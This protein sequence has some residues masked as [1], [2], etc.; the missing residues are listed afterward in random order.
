MSLG[1]RRRRPP[2]PGYVA[3]ALWRRAGAVPSFHINPAALG[4]AR[5]LI[6]GTVL[7]GGT[8]NSATP[9]WEAGPGGILAQPAANSPV[10]AYDPVTLRPLGLRDWQGVTNLILDSA[11][12]SAASYTKTATTV[13]A[14]GTGPDNQ[15]AYSINETTSTTSHTI[16]PSA[17]SVT[18]GV[19]YTAS[20]FLKRSTVDWVQLTVG[21]AGFSNSRFANFNL[22]TG[23]IGIQSNCTGFIEPYPN[24]WYRCSIRVLAVATA[25]SNS[26]I[27]AFT[28]N[29]DSATRLPSYAGSTSNEVLAA[30]VAFT[31]TSGPAPYVP[32]TATTASSTAEAIDITSLPGGINNIRTVY[33]R[34]R[35]PASGIRGIISLNDNSSSNRLE[36]L[37]NGTD[38]R[39]VAVTSGSTVA[40][41]NGGTIAANT[42][43]K[44]AA[45]FDGDN[46]AVSINGA[47]VVTDN[48]G[49]RAIVDRIFLGR[50]Q[51]GEHLNGIIEELA[52]WTQPLGNSQLQAVAA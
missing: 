51:A 49:A 48:A 6:T 5:D 26:L 19:T 43:F 22:A 12:L 10:I 27:L 4:H 23:T 47:P 11:N 28:N 7:G 13:S 20:I 33:A 29:T 24:G 36:L 42:T 50:T 1:A 39:A 3:N 8:V 34:V 16:G 41:I 44:I 37:T 30:L 9:A 32:T 2:T 15:T 14:S 17:V 46:Y 40:D 31:A 52:T 35:T 18:S 21:N 45:R 25:T 38:P